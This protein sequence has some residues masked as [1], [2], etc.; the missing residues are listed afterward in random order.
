M[1]IIPF[2]NMFDRDSLTGCAD[3]QQF[4]EADIETVIKAA[5]GFELPYVALDP[6][7]L[8]YVQ[9]TRQIVGNSALWWRE[10]GHGY[11][12]N[13]D[14]AWRVPGTWTG[15]DTDVLRACPEVDALAER[16][17]DVQRLGKL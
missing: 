2:Y 12:C 14:E 8:F 1:Y 6:E 9:D 4:S 17:V 13:L 7:P 3:D 5:R 15:R 11:T 16:H 10:G